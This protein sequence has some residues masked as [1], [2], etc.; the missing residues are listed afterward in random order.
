MYDLSHWRAFVRRSALLIATILAALSC[1]ADTEV[2][3]TEDQG[4][5]STGSTIAKVAS[6]E[7][8]GQAV[9]RPDVRNN[10][11]DFAAERVDA[12][13]RHAKCMGAAADFR[14]DFAHADDPQRA[15]G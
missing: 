10:A 7:Q 4:S 2:P 5:N 8:I 13:N 6:I 12:E 14:S 1:H 15:I 9:R 11:R 3:Q